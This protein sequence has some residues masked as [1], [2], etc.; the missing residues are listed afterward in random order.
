METGV[1]VV[2]LRDK[3]SETA[4]LI[5][6][7]R[8]LHRVTQDHGI[9]LIINDRADVAVAIGAEGLHIGQEDIGVELMEYL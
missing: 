1:T 8:A 9:P 4:D 5:R 6:T 7:A 3:T 2:Q